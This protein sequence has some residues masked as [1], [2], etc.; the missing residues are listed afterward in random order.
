VTFRKSS[1]L[2]EVAYAIGLNA[3]PSTT[4]S[5][6]VVRRVV[7]PELEKLALPVMKTL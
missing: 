1:D 7:G 6:L 5:R 4:I 3:T 2:E